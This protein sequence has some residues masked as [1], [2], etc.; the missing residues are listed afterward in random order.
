MKMQIG[1]VF[2]IQI[3]RSGNKTIA[4]D[5]NTD[6]KAIARCHPDDTY[7]EYLGAKIALDR[8]FGREPF[9]EPVEEDKPEYYNGKV[10]LTNRVF[11]DIGFTK[12][13]IYEIVDGKIVSDLGETYP[14]VNNLKNFKDVSNYFMGDVIEIKE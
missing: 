4:Y 2:P 6:K 1:I 13:K 12:G 8:L 10:V 14:T 5:P 9:P 11:K 3:N 7:D